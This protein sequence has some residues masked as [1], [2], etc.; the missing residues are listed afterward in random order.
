MSF[1]LLRNI[2]TCPRM[3]ALSNAQYPNLWPK[4]GYPK[5]ANPAT[6]T[7]LVVHRA[8]KTIVDA[9][10]FNG[11]EDIS[12]SKAASALRNLGGVSQII[13][14]EIVASLNELR[15]NPR[16]RHR[17]DLLSHQMRS[18]IGDVR[19]KL[20]C[21][22]R[23]LSF[24]SSRAKAR[25]TFIGEGPMCLQNGT[26]TELFIAVEEMKWRGIVD[27]FRLTDEHCEILDY[28]TGDFNH[29]HVEQLH[30]YSLLWARCSV[31]NPSGRLADILTLDFGS[32][33]RRFSGLSE[34]Q[35]LSVE[36]DLNVRTRN[37]LDDCASRLPMT[38]TGEHCLDCQVRHLCDE[39]WSGG[40]Q[41]MI[42][43]FVP[44]G[45]HTVDAEVTISSKHASKSY[46]SICTS[47]FAL[48]QGASALLR[49]REGEMQLK[50]GDRLRL[51]DVMFSSEDSGLPDSPTLNMTSRSEGFVT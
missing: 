44:K 23:E 6:L 12:D 29:Q 14:S 13:E 25:R 45:K 51:L 20:Q 18:K 48:Q 3:W 1:S 19:L 47:S 36:H 28:K 26:Y 30:V 4:S 9:F 10:L 31:M 42:S 21:L 27:L 8:L 7:G 37:A 22:L 33:K 11:V 49:V 16:V 40:T 38:R 2:E 50:V 34:A 17:L 15:S 35:L 46:D 39:Y 32:E 5:K 41:A 24:G 43:K